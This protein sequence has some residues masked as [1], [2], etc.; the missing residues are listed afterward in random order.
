MIRKSGRLFLC[1]VILLSAAGAVFFFPGY[2]ACETVNAGGIEFTMPAGWVPKSAPGA[3]AAY[4]L[5]FQG[6]PYAEMYLS[7][8]ALN[9]PKTASQLLEDG[10]RK[11]SGNLSGYRSLGS[12]NVRV[13][14][15]DGVVLDFSYYIPQTTVQF[16][17]RLLVLV[18][19]EAAYSFF[20]NT[21][22]SY[23]PYVK[24]SFE[25]IASSV[26]AVE[27]PAPAQVQAEPAAPAATTP[28]V[29]RTVEEHC[30]LLDLAPGWKDAPTSGGAKYRFYNEKGNY[31]A[32]FFPDGTNPLDQTIA[33][34]CLPIKEDPLQAVLDRKTAENKKEEG[35]KEIKTEKRTVAGCPA[36]LHDFS[37]RITGGGTAIQRY[38]LI[39]VKDKPDTGSIMYPPSIYNFR[40]LISANRFAEAETEIEALLNSL[41]LKTPL[42]VQGTPATP[43]VTGPSA[44]APEGSQL[45]ELPE[46]ELPELGGEEDEGVFHGP[47]GTFTV[48]LPEGSIPDRELN[49]V[50]A[51]GPGKASTYTI[52][53]KEG[54]VIVLNASGSDADGIVYR[55]TLSE[56]LNARLSSD[57]AWTVEGRD[58][59]VRIFTTADGRVLAAALFPHH[60]FFIGVLLPRGEYNEARGWIRDMIMSV[61]KK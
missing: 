52:P 47:G 34:M 5:Y 55:N 50:F 16:T 17:G 46:Q 45:P 36:L 2:G 22:S 20:F 13:A 54:T 32:G 3:K 15:T 60:G 23:F 51:G 59:P 26:K 48:T 41:R 31:L 6:K 33:V 9:E 44:A 28:G 19:N 57:T 61:K 14:G 49:P 21:T 27:K 39:A 18:V 8:E 37:T 29:Q 4:D 58:V 43:A 30:F 56:K 40:F 35:Y 11:N 25:E 42:P 38:C 1:G 53:G 12:S 10:I 24:G 7:E